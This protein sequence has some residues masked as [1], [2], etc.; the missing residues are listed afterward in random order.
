M[1]RRDAMP[2]E[3]K[4]EF[5][6]M[7]D[8]VFLLLI[9][10][11][12]IPIKEM[13]AKLETKVSGKKVDTENIEVEPPKVSF[14]IDLKSEVNGDE[15]LTRVS[16]NSS[17][18]ARLISPSPEKIK[19]LEERGGE[20][21]K[22]FVKRQRAKDMVQA[23]PD[24][25]P[26]L[27]KMSRVLLRAVVGAPEGLDTPVIIRSG[28]EVPFKWVMAVFNAGVGVN[29]KNLSFGAPGDEIWVPNSI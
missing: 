25:S 8:V 14:Q 13:E 15:V 28:P 2:D 4:V 11:M 6:S 9:F 16:V 7:I 21:W 22:R 27:Q 3:V 18:V 24:I 12:L 20:D 19:A 29:L 5:T 23:D 1:N 26:E 10:F 17:E